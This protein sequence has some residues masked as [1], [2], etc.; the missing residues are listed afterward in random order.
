MLTLR[1]PPC[2]PPPAVGRHRTCHDRRRHTFLSSPSAK[3]YPPPSPRLRTGRTVRAVARARSRSALES[4][5]AAVRRRYSGGTAAVRRW[6]GGGGD[7]AAWIQSL[8]SLSVG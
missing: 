4:A 6:Y 5:A 3:P 2:P 7:G 8:T 1:R